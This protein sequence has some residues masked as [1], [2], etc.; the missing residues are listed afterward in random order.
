M[1]SNRKMKTNQAKNLIDSIYNQLEQGKTFAELALKYS[2]DRKTAKTGGELPWV[3][4]G[5]LIPKYEDAAFAIKNKDEYTKPVKTRYGWHIIKL[6]DKK[7]IPNFEEIKEEIKKKVSRDA[8]YKESK[9]AVIEKLKI[10][11]DFTEIREAD[12]KVLLRKFDRIYEIIPDSITE[13]KWEIKESDFK[14]NPVIF[15]FAEEEVKLKEFAEFLY[16]SQRAN[17]KIGKRKLIEQRYK[18]FVINKIMDYEDKN[19][20]KKYPDFNLLVREYHDGILLFSLTDE[21]VWA[22]SLSDTIGLKN[23]YKENKK[24]Y[25]WDEKRINA[26]IY[27]IKDEKTATKILKYMQKNKSDNYIK[28]KINKKETILWISENNFLKADNEV[29]DKIDW[30]EGRTKIIENKEKFYIVNVIKVNN[31]P[32]QKSFRYAKAEVSSDY[33]KLLE[34]NWIKQLKKKYKYS[35]DKTILYNL[36]D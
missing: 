30:K 8:R 5:Q 20:E 28:E 12:D 1:L 26:K 29:I 33:Q 11:Y 32:S 14:E 19:L 18:A 3:D 10:E 36:I 24:K 16:K 35:V 6:I 9:E 25:Q 27:T 13:G 23:Y 22:K 17:T 31:P 21:K 7:P 15:S 34:N 2:D 4:A